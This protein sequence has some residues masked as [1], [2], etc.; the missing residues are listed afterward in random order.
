M[1]VTLWNH[2]IFLKHYNVEHD[3]DNQQQPRDW[4]DNEAESSNQWRNITHANEGIH[5]EE[6]NA[7]LPLSAVA[8]NGRRRNRH[9]KVVVGED[10]LCS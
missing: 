8:A 4:D 6:L 1:Y 5:K 3:E 7:A 10:A 2:L 9:E